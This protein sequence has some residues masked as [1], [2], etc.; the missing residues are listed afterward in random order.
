[1]GR[2]LVLGV[3]PATAYA[4][5]FAVSALGCVAG[6]VRARRIQDA[7]TRLGLVVLL[8]TSGVWSAS[9]AGLLVL[10]SRGLK[11]GVYLV[12]LIFGFSTVFAWLYFCSAYTGRTYHRQ[13]VYRRAGVAFYLVVFAI[14][15]TNPIH[16]LYFT[17]GFVTEPFP[18]L[19]IQQ[20]LFHWVVTGISYVL[21]AVGMFAL[22]EAFVEADYETGP[23]AVLVALAGLPVVLDILGSA[24]P[25]LIDMIHAPLGVT[26]F[27]VGVLFVF[28]DRFFAV[29]LTGGVAGATVFLDDDS[30]IR[31]F[32]GAARRL[33]PGLDNAV[34]DTVDALPGVAAALDDSTGVV[35]VDVDGGQR[36]YVVNE[37]AFD[38]GQ[39]SLSRIVVF[40]DVTP[41]E[42]QRRE[43]ERHD[44]QL[45]DISKG[46]RHELRNAV[47]IIQGNVRLAR[48]QLEDGSVEDARGA[49]RTATDTTDRATRLMNDF[50]TVAQYGQT[51]VD[52]AT[53]DITET[54]TAAW[55]DVDG[56]GASLTVDGGPSVEVDPA[57]FE[58]LLERAFEFLVDNGA[59]TVTV[60]RR[61]GALTVTGDGEP[62][63]EDPEQYFD[64]SDAAAHE[65][66]GTTLPLVRTLAQVHGWQAAIDPDYRDGVRVVLALESTPLDE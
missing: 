61:D 12:G 11:T 13:Q 39:G 47:T 26:A 43:L 63:R 54:A 14:K 10:P 52:A 2:Q 9:H 44:R 32:N 27:A 66:I 49:L 55:T 24:S 41:L 64:Y 51:M 60:A 22:F 25:L 31:E 45:E 15:I 21:A 59:T 20:G 34:G 58:L 42:R 30:R 48:H 28:E 62:P 3:S 7:E 17:T 6:T 36:H 46:M 1:V 4:A 18:H 53:V 37:S 56:E 35:D 8:A 5:A 40:S 19:A 50:A 16:Q 29:Q 38:V 57:R 33:F 23:L 65:T